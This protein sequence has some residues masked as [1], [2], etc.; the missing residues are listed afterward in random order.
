MPREW[1]S[2]VFFFLSKRSENQTHHLL[3]HSGLYTLSEARTILS[4]HYSPN[5]TNR[6][7]CITEMHCVLCEVGTDMNVSLPWVATCWKPS[8]HY[9]YRQFNIQQFYVQ[10]TQ[11]Y[12]CVLCGSENKQ[13]LFHYT[14]LTHWFL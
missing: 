12:L 3:Q 4:D 9:T 2:L 11:L 5:I 10:P 7:V 13:R 8:G 6:L 14:T 1:Q